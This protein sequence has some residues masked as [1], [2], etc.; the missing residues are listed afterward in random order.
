MPIHD[1]TRVP[2][3]LFHDFHQSW[4]IRIKD[5]LN[6]GALPKGLWALVEQ[7]SG[8]KES[9]VLTVETDSR[10]T[11][12][13]QDDVAGLTLDRPTA[14]LTYRTTKQIYAGRANRIA[15]KHYLGRT[16]AVIE[17]LSPGNK[18]SRA[19]VRVFVDKT[20]DIMGPEFTFC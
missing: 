16:V 14:Q 12:L 10:L 8:P 5:A 19:A 17:I 2:S 15:I 1:W 9:D 4:S 7:R 3:G 6:A 20:I 11:R 13:K 18:D